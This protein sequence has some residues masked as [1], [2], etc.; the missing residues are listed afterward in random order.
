VLPCKH[1][2]KGSLNAREM[3]ALWVGEDMN[4]PRLQ[5]GSNP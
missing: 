3:A 4:A 2:Y 5:D 1:P